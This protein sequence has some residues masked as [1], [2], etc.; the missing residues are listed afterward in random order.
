MTTFIF[1]QHT[2]G[3]PNR[4]QIV[5]LVALKVTDDFSIE[6]FSRT[7]KPQRVLTEKELNELGITNAYLRSAPI[8]VEIIE[9]FLLFLEHSSLRIYDSQMTRILKNKFRKIGLPI[10]FANNTLVKDLTKYDLKYKNIS[11]DSLI[12]MHVSQSEESFLEKCHRVL[13]LLL[14]IENTPVGVSESAF[15]KAEQNLNT[16]LRSIAQSAPNGPGY[17]LFLND[18][19]E[20]IYVGKAKNLKRRLKSHLEE[21]EI[22][23]YNILQSANKLEFT[24]TGSE[25]IAKLIESELIFKLQP[26]FN[27]QQTTKISPWIITSKLD[28]KGILRLRAEEKNFSDECEG[29]S[30]NRASGLD[31]LKNLKLLFNICPK[32]SGLERLAL[33]CNDKNCKGVC[34]GDED[35]AMYNL[36]VQKAMS[37]LNQKSENFYLKLPGRNQ[38]EDSFILVQEKFYRGYGFIP[39]SA[40]VNSINDLESFLRPQ[41]HNYFTSRSINEH[42]KLFKSIKVSIS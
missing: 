24:P 4:S 2:E 17:Y 9:E 42:I 3:T 31:C 33:S 7:I 10:S 6:S 40:V 27:T 19:D 1:L 21:K 8:F 15:A 37:Y 26:K 20:V 36:R 25:L 28:S 41:Q 12:E 35:S 29:L 39:K 38:T 16:D 32:L 11:I 22:N 34:R 5:E 23:S 13:E 18:S 14:N 30:F